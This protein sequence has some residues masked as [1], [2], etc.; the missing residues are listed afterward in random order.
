MAGPYA[1]ILGM[2]SYQSQIELTDRRERGAS[3]SV[4]KQTMV[5]NVQPLRSV[6]PPLRGSVQNILNGLNDLNDLNRSEAT[7]RVSSLLQARSSRFAPIA[8]RNPG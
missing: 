7:G 1:S 8:L 4:A 2:T 6:Q 5:Q 3:P